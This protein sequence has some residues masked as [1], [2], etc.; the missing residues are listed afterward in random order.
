[1][2]SF[3]QFFLT[4][5]SVFFDEREHSFLNPMRPLVW[6]M[7]IIFAP[8]LLVH[9]ILLPR[10]RLWLSYSKKGIAQ[11]RSTKDL[12]IPPQTQFNPQ[13]RIFEIPKTMLTDV[14][15]IEHVLLNV[16][17]YMH[18]GDVVNLSLT[19]R[20][21]REVVYPPKDLDYRVPKLM[22]HCEYSLP[23]YCLPPN[24]TEWFQFLAQPTD[25]LSSGCSFGEQNK[26]LYC[27]NKLCSF[28]QHSPLWPG[29]SGRRHVTECKPYC[30]TCYYKSFARHPRNYKRPCKCYSNDRSNRFQN[31]CQSCMRKGVETLQA[32]RHKRYQQE[33]RDIAYE[34]DSKCKSCKT[35]LKDGMRW[36]ICGQC[37][38]ECRNKI[39]PGFVKKK[40]NRAKAKDIEKGDL[41]D[42]EAE[43]NVSWWRKWRNAL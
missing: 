19:C 10:I 2:H 27:N 5:V 7:I 41:R 43:E 37:G 28:C 21:V 13:Y 22:R 25:V 30:E 29:L 32:A 35:A 33:A 18:F 20:A 12:Q 14:F 31:V 36:W 23:S 4:Y 24:A 26:C 40:K 15:A 38:G 8:I 6:L 17:D 42:G 3:F 11:L 1:M 16:V 9:D 34:E 39:H